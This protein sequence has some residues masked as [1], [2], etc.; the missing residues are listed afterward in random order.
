MSFKVL[1]GPLKVGQIV[2]KIAV[3]NKIPATHLISAMIYYKGNAE[4]IYKL[5]DMHT[6]D[7]AKISYILKSHILQSLCDE[8][9]SHLPINE[10]RQKQASYIL[11]MNAPVTHK[12]S[13]HTNF[14]F[15][16]L[17]DIHIGKHIRSVVKKMGITQKK[18]GELIQLSQSNISLLFSTKTIKV[19]RL[20]YISHQ[21]EHNFFYE[22]Y[23]SKMMI[24]PSHKFY[25]HQMIYIYKGH[26][27]VIN[28]NDMT[29]V[30]T[31]LRP[32]D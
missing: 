29:I 20:L 11:E 18:M 1:L 12:A 26:T 15:K 14:N 19:K 25:G 27:E 2:K 5:D 30:A 16:F 9:L 28:P 8:Y 10:N 17:D 24:T 7:V 31:F 32:Q 22:P 13:E 23:L 6:V 4:K 21:L 3:Q